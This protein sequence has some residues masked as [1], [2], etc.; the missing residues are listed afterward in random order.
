MSNVSNAQFASR[1]GL[2]DNIARFDIDTGKPRLPIILIGDYVQNTEACANLSKLLPVPV[3]TS[4]TTFIQTRNAPCDP[5]ARRG[6]WLEARLGRLLQRGDWQAGY[7]RIFVEREA[8]LGN[9]DYSEMR[10]GSNVTAHRLELFY[11]LQKS[12]QLGLTVL[13]GRPLATTEHYL[14]RV[15]FDTVYIF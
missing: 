4:T 10:Q 3:N 15:Q 8:V 5:H 14:T 11:Q 7:T 1:F 6:Y 12:V 13:S 9:F 2:F